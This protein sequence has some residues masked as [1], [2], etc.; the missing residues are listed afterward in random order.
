MAIDWGYV[1]PFAAIEFQVSPSDEVYVWREHY[2]A[3]R[4]V[5]EHCELMKKRDN[6]AG[7]HL[8]LAFGDAADPEA[9][10]V[11]SRNLVRCYTDP[12]AKVNWR[13]G[14]DLMTSLMQSH[15][16]GEVADEYGT[17][18]T[19]PHYFIDP[20]C[21]YAVREHMNYKRSDTVTT[22][23]NESGKRAPTNKQDD[24]TVDAARYGM[25]HIFKLGARQHLS[26]VV[27]ANSGPV[28]IQTSVSAEPVRTSSYEGLGVITTATERNSGTFFNL[29]MVDF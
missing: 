19:K 5:A 11:V 9:A 21:K 2:L 10:E 8:D 6:P 28:R 25:M 13:E 17:P 24:H 22:H 16:T 12:L 20:S 18:I 15:D 14:I 3:Y 7:Y 23:T 27:E 4:T 29:D 1:S 26:D